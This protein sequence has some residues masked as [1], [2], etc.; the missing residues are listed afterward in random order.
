MLRSPYEPKPK[1]DVG[2]ARQVIEILTMLR[3]KTTNN[4][5]A[6]EDDFCPHIWE[7]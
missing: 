4:L 6:D 2:A 1:V 3:E 5:T 7:N